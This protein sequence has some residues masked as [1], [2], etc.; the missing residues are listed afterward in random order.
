MGP[1]FEHVPLLVVLF[2]LNQVCETSL[3]ETDDHAVATHHQWS[4]NQRGMLNHEL[5]QLF[6]VDF[7]IGKT[8]GLVRPA[9]F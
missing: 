4:T 8:Q 7:P 9:P 1:K 6:I 2:A 3:I 5:N